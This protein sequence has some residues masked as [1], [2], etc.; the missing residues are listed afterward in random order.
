MFMERVVALQAIETSVLIGN[1]MA[2]LSAISIV[3][4]QDHRIKHR[5]VTIRPGDEISDLNCAL[6]CVGA[7]VGEGI[8]RLGSSRLSSI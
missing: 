5:A 8:G 1:L 2:S 6:P 3:Q 7:K 4:A